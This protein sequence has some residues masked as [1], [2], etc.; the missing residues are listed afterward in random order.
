[1]LGV[2]QKFPEFNLTSVVSIDPK[3]G[4]RAILE[5]GRCRQ[6]AGDLLLAQGL[7]IRVSDRDRRVRQ[8]EA[9]FRGS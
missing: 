3:K 8:V 6:V 2:G 9:G 1:M 5:P 7:H 4:L